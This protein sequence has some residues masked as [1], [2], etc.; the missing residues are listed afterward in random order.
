MPYIKQEYRYQLDAEI[1]ELVRKI[2][3]S[4]MLKNQKLAGTLNYCF[5]RIILDILDSTGTNYENINEMI[6]ML[7]C[8]KQE[9]YRKVAVPYEDEKEIENGS[10]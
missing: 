8:C 6:G 4:Y 1:N 9:L 3:N 2:I 10:V 7:E 5:T